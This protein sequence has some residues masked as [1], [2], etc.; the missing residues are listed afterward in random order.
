[1][2]PSTI[3]DVAIACSPM[4]LLVMLCLQNIRSSLRRW[5]TIKFI[6]L[7]PYYHREEPVGIRVIFA[8]FH[9]LAANVQMYILIARVLFRI[10]FL[11]LSPSFEAEFVRLLP[12]KFLEYLYQTQDLSV[13]LTPDQNLE[14]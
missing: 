14:F 9:K 13:R 2:Y 6:C 1:M 12:P 10:R 5:F 11:F 4:A 7:E 3:K 8:R